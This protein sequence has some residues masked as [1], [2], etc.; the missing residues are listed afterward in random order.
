MFHPGSAPQE[1]AKAFLRPEYSY[2]Q[3]LSGNAE[4][5][6]HFFSAPALQKI[7]LEQQSVLRCQGRY[8]LAGIFGF[9]AVGRN[10]KPRR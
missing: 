7:F 8:Y 6:R 2:S 3:V 10:G 9:A 5:M 1:S 4:S